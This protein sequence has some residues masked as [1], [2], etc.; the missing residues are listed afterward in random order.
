MLTYIATLLG[1][2]QINRDTNSN[3]QKI[4]QF[5]FF[6]HRMISK[7]KSEVD[8]FG[9]SVEDIDFL[10]QVVHNLQKIFDSGFFHVSVGN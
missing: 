2:A 5:W 8:V 10:D 9:M 7:V 1:L 4:D 6:F 3:T